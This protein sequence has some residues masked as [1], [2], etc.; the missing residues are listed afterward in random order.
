[1]A[2]VAVSP[3]PLTL[4]DGLVLENLGFRYPGSDDFALR[5]VNLLLPAGGVVAF[6]GENGAGKTT[7]VK[8]ISGLYQPTEGRVRLDS[9]DLAHVEP[10]AWRQVVGAGFQDFCRFEFIAREAIGV[11]H[12][13]L[14]N[15][16]P[17]VTRS[18]EIAGANRLA[19]SLRHGLETQFGSTW[20]EGTDL[21]GGQWQS[22]ALARGAMRPEP[23]LIILDEPTAAL[24]PHAEH[25][26]FERISEATRL[27][28]A[29]GRIT[30][31]VSH[32]FSTAR[33]ADLIVVLE[34]GQVVETGSHADLVRRGGLYSELFE[35]QARAYR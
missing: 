31:L 24:D 15:H 29:N 4:R 1:T 13:P 19:S 17:S 14:I 8:L 22:V 34:K 6:I 7:L 27:N 32:R 26:L 11:G 33:M 9:V 12:L 10:R 18:L 3:P 30:V 28:S 35:I 25:D 5:N 21:S 16:L 23:I 20:P 2:R